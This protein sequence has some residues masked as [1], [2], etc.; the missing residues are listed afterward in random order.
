MMFGIV[1]NTTHTKTNTVLQYNESSLIELADKQDDF[2]NA[3]NSIYPYVQV[4]IGFA[5]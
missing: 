3:I 5:N 2:E 1:E 4:K